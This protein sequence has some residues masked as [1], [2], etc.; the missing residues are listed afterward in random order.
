[1]TR[2]IIRRTIGAC[3]LAAGLLGAVSCGD[4]A[5]QGRSPGFLIIDSLTAASGASPNEFGNVLYSDVQTLV[6]QQV[7]GETV[8]VPTVYSDLGRVSLR[9]G[10]KNPGTTVNPTQPTTI[11]EITITRY[12]VAFERAD[13]R[14][15]PG[16]DLPY[17]FDGGATVTVGAASSVSMGFDLVRHQMKEEP[18]LRNLINSG[19]ANLI[20]TIATITF[21]GRDQAGNDVEASG[22]M[23]VNF[24]DFGDPQ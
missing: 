18:P 1:M 24:G 15:T 11:N 23:T 20:S 12:H 22:K 13:G 7:N 4:V 2:E 5:R 10:L 14:N 16:I 3:A 17:G 8:R 6:D 9:L 21:Y 19:G